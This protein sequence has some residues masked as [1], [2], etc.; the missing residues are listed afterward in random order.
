MAANTM[1]ELALDRR[2][3]GARRWTLRRDLDCEDEW[4]E[5]YWATDWAEQERRAARMSAE[6]ERLRGRI[7]AFHR[8]DTPPRVRRWLVSRKKRCR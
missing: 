6:T 4:V 2:R 7:L 8:E 1:A 3:N 5:S